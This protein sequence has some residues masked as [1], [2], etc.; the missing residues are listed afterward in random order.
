MVG[1]IGIL[2]DEG[3]VIESPDHTVQRVLRGGSVLGARGRRQ[4]RY[5]LDCQQHVREQL[6]EL[7]VL[8]LGG[9][10][11]RLTPGRGG[12]A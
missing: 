2:V 7:S 1:D 10:G 11:G 6:V 8:L 4:V 12:T 5:V 3:D 9:Q